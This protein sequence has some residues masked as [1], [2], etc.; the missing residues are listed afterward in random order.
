M[1]GNDTANTMIH[2]GQTKKNRHK[3]DENMPQTAHTGKVSK[4]YRA[5]LS[6]TIGSSTLAMASTT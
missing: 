3:I 6:P 4:A 2:E 1:H 5:G